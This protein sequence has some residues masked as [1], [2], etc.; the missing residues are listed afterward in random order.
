VD[1]Y[2]SHIAA[3]KYA[4]DST[5]KRHDNLNRLCENFAK[6]AGFEDVKVEPTDIKLPRSKKRVDLIA[7]D[8][9]NDTTYLTD[10]HVNSSL[11]AGWIN[12]TQQAVGVETDKAKRTKY[13][14]LLKSLREGNPH[15]SFSFFPLF[16]K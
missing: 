7:V 9:S 3:C 6:R 12:R 16:S 15:M 14:T 5:V 2:H 11:S 10:V 8:P 1:R 13:K 4:N